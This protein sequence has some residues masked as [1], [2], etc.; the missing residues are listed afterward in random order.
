MNPKQEQSERE[1]Q[2]EEK[3]IKLEVE[4]DKQ[5]EKRTKLEEELDEMNQVRKQMESRRTK[6]ESERDEMIEKR[7]KLEEERE[8][9]K[10]ER[11]EMKGELKKLHK[12]CSL[13]IKILNTV[14]KLTKKLEERLDNKNTNLTDQ[15]QENIQLKIFLLNSIEEQNLQIEEQN[16]QIDKQNEQIKE[17]NILIDKQNKLIKEQN[18]RIELSQTNQLNLIETTKKMKMFSIEKNKKKQQFEKK[19]KGEGLLEFVDREEELE[20][21]FDILE[22]NFNERGYEK[23]KR[24]HNF[25]LI[26][27]GAGLGKTRLGDEFLPFCQKKCSKESILF[28]QQDQ[29][30]KPQQNRNQTNER[31]QLMYRAILNNSQSLY[32]DLSNGSKFNPE[33]DLKYQPEK[34]KKNKKIQDEKNNTKP[35]SFIPL[36][37]IFHI[38]EFQLYIDQMTKYL[39]KEMKNKNQQQISFENKQDCYQESKS[40][41]KELLKAIGHIM[42]HFEEICIV[43]ICT[44]TS[45]FDISFLSTEYSRNLINLKPL[46]FESIKRI[47]QNYT[48]QLK[49]GFMK[50]ILTKHLIDEEKNVFQIILGDIGSIPRYL[51]EFQ[52][53]LKKYEKSFY[54]NQSNVESLNR[55]ETKIFSQLN[56]KYF[57]G[58][59]HKNEEISKRIL[60][61]SLLLIPIYRNDQII[62]QNNLKFHDLERE[63][64]L[65]L[66]PSSSTSEK[67]K[68]LV[69]IPF[70]FLHY[71]NQKYLIFENQY[72][73]PINLKEEW[74]WQDFENFHLEF[75][76]VYNNTL[77]N[78]Y[79]KNTK[80]T[81]TTTTTSSSSLSSSS[82]VCLPLKTIYRG[83]YISNKQSQLIQLSNLKKYFHQNHCIKKQNSILINNNFLKILNDLDQVENMK[84]KIQNK[85]SCIIK[86]SKGNPLVDSFI[87]RYDNNLKPVLIS[88][89]LK[90]TVLSNNL[91][92]NFSQI[93]KWYKQTKKCIE[94]GLTNKNKNNPIFQHFFY[95]WL[96]NRQISECVNQQYLDK[97][98]DLIIICQSNLEVYLG[99]N[100][101]HRGLLAFNKP[102][103]ERE[104]EKEKEK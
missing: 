62:Q 27:G 69:Y 30:K 36:I 60:E 91:T 71:L 94:N 15:E 90:H 54:E 48:K 52:K 24:A 59:F 99:K 37:F 89:Q 56:I 25:I 61:L 40:N 104:Q 22:K 12:K 88:C 68:F 19:E 83:A 26:P 49:N 53:L 76:R 9:M 29:N 47:F 34:K 86:C 64:T 50:Q 35:N 32:M 41:F 87:I 101:A 73:K 97:N 74:N 93:K 102:D 98:P 21:M 78:Y 8:E 4:L 51:N 55:I 92:I 82:I 7:N 70:I 38:D 95:F 28:L 75:E 14:K 58:E 20:T 6:L 5:K 39:I 79:K 16:I 3:R 10:E 43:P 80:I 31:V 65:F 1:K 72:L 67:N 2:M 18:Q 23:E 33:I 85:E 103:R 66:I 17:Q 96:T 63:G 81:K 77:F 42:T 100:L 57:F 11:D 13:K 44:G 84:E 46:K 45:E